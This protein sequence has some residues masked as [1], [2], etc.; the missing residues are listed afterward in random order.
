M[1]DAELSRGLRW[2]VGLILVVATR[3]PVAAA[4]P[5]AI[6]FNGQIRPIL[7][8]NCFACHGPDKHARQADLRLDQRDAALAAGAIVARDAHS[9]TLVDRITSADPDQV[10]PPPKTGK[11]LTAE[12]LEL[13]R[14]WIESGA[15]YQPHWAFVPVP[16]QIP[17]PVADSR[18]SNWP[19]SDLDRLVLAGI[20]AHQM[21]PAAEAEK[22]RWLRR[23]RFDLTG[24]PPTRDEIRDFLADTS[25][26]AYEKMVERLLAMD[27]FGE[28]MASVWLD[29]A[30]YADTFGYQADV[31]ME[32]WPWRDW[33]IRAFNQ[34]LPYNDFIRWQVAGDLMPG[35]TQDQRLATTFNRL[36]RQTNEGGSIE[37][38]FRQVYVADRTVTAGTALL[39]L[40]L[41]CSRC[42]D[43]KYDP[44]TQQDFYSLASYFANIDEHGL[45]S[46]FTSATP[47]PALLLYSGDQQARHQELLQQITAAESELSRLVEQGREAWLANGRP[48]APQVAPPTTPWSFPLEGTESGVVGQATKFNGDD[49]VS[50]TLAG[51]ANVSGDDGRRQLG[52]RDAFSISLWVKPA[53]HAHRVVIAHQSVAAEDSAFRGLQLVLEEGRPQFSL[54]HFWPGD[55]IRVEALEPIPVHEWTHLGVVYD[56]SSRAAGVKLYVNGQSIPVRVDRDQLSR[57][58]LH[59]SEWGDSSAG[60]VGFSLGARFRDIGFRDGV[61]DELQVFDRQL[62]PMEMASLFA[63]VSAIASERR[64]A[65]V[66]SAGQDFDSLS[67]RGNPAYDSAWERLVTV[68]KSENELVTQVRQVMAMSPAKQPRTTRVLARGAYDSPSEPV[69][70]RPPM[71]LI[72]AAGLDLPPVAERDRRQL[73]EWLVSDTNPLVSRV[74]VNRFWQVFFGRGIV[75]S[76][77]D[78]GS[79][80]QPPTHP[81]LLDWLARDFMDHGWD[82]KRLCRQIVLSAAYRQSSQPRQMEWLQSDPDNRWLARGPRYRLSAEQV[83]DGALAAA[84]LL[85]PTVGG[86]S[87]MPYQPAGVW[88]EAGT[89]KT[90]HQSQ[91]DGVYRRSLYTFWRRTAPPPNMLT[92][93][94]TSRETCTARR[95]VTTT[96]LQALV[97]LNDPQFVEACRVLAERSVRDQPAQPAQRWDDLSLRLLTRPLSPEELKVVERTYQEQLAYFQG[98]GAA[99]ES[100]LAVGQHPRDTQLNPA[101]VAATTVVAELLMCFDEFVMKR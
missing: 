78:F 93:D 72:S 57:D 83:R 101:D 14:A 36:H 81:E 84:E 70:A 6:S 48:A 88:E 97:L 40:T 51:P 43:H 46:H 67:L 99:A 73:A 85:V 10:M 98:N 71:M 25:D 13:L 49:A 91:G 41:E 54:I 74:A 32:V 47:T 52:R 23:V 55:A 89:G 5:V 8:D 7:S 17:V 29:V 62:S 12:Q 69:E 35:A 16:K 37:E 76:L 68:R 9:S 31:N 58:I 96:P 64:E 30:R 75:A 50:F 38:E 27:S 21:E 26:G 45:Y 77:E 87:V 79:Q 3:V 86:P 42:H 11:K 34:N 95:E 53:E 66:A 100:F 44:L 90:Y 92:F 15:E 24:L 82:V 33:V 22:L 20:V 80:G 19:R 4:E 63:S 94:A 28:R 65:A 1:S 18:W 2:A 56:G 60:Q 39:G 61:M 59:R